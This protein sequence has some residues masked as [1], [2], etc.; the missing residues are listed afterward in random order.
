MAGEILHAVD[1][2]IIPS[3]NPD[4]YHFTWTEVRNFFWFYHFNL[5]NFNRRAKKQKA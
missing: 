4:G 3:S 1:F 5:T 2:Y